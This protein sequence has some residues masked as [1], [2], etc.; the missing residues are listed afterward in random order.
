MILGTKWKEAS[1]KVCFQ[2][3]G[4]LPTLERTK[5]L[6][7]LIACKARA[8]HNINDPLADAAVWAYASWAKLGR[9]AIVSAGFSGYTIEKD[10][11]EKPADHHFHWLK[12][13]NVDF[14]LYPLEPQ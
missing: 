11:L 7:G 1:Q 4:L 8:R 9:E 12:T 5:V 6:A 14:D 10:F 13:G 2:E 3:V